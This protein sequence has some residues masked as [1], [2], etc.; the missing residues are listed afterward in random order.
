M[1]DQSSRLSLNRLILDA[2]RGAERPLTTVEVIAAVVVELDY[3]PDAAAGMK[4]RVRSSLLYL[5][6]VRGSVVKDGERASATWVL[7]AAHLNHRC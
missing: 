1:P 7:N 4:G 6:K 5:S 3:G 2:L